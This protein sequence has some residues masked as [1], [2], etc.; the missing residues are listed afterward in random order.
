[1]IN[2][3]FLK[4]ADQLAERNIY[5]RKF[6]TSS[7]FDHIC[8]IGHLPQVGM[9][10]TEYEMQ[11]STGEEG[12]FTSLIMDWP[13]ESIGFSN[14]TNDLDT[15]PVNTTW[16]RDGGVISLIDYTLTLRGSCFKP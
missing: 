7:S 15:L 10:R 5:L 2:D 11:L 16:Q 4:L 3:D 14:P 13:F 1:M 8:A 12:A 6:G 9:V